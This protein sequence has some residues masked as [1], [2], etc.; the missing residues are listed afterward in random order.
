M[1]EMIGSNPF[2][3]KKEQ[4]DEITAKHGLEINQLLR[5]LIPIAQLF[6]RPP[7]SNYHVGVAALGKK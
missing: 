4:V 6:S 2:V 3:I 5:E 1:R 7:I